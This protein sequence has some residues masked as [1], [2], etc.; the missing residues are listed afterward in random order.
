MPTER[1]TGL[2]P[3]LP[4]LDVMLRQLTTDDVVGRLWTGD[5]SLWHPSADTQA[6]I[7]QRLGWLQLPASL[8]PTLDA[9]IESVAMSGYTSVVIVVAGAAAATARLWR[10]AA[11]SPPHTLNIVLIDTIEPVAASALLGNLD[12]EQAVVVFLGVELS[13][14]LIALCT[15]VI[16]RLD[17][18]SWNQNR[19]LVVTTPES[20]LEQ[21]LKP[22]ISA[23]VIMLPPTVSERFGALSALGWV[24]ARLYGHN[25]ADAVQAAGQMRQA[26]HNTADLHANP[27]VWLGVVLGVLAQQGR[28]ILTLVASPAL[29]P[30]AHWIASFVAGS[31]SKHR[32]GF[33]PVVDETFMPLGYRNNRIFVHIS[34][35]DDMNPNLSRHLNALEAAEQPVVR[36]TLT[37]SADIGAEIARWEVAVAVA[38]III[39]LN[40]FDEP[41]ADAMQRF[42]Q[43]RIEVKLLPETTNAM[44]VLHHDFAATLRLL[45][46]R[47]RRAGYVALVCYFEPGHESRIQLDAICTLLQQRYQLAALLVYPLR[48]NIASAQL[49]HAGRDNGI[50]VAL[51]TESK[52]D[53]DVPE[54]DEALGQL[55]I[56]RFEADL[57]G[58]QRLGHTHLAVNL[59]ANA[60]DGLRH[61]QT[62]FA[63]I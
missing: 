1:I 60:G 26:C 9:W 49:L 37:N 4:L 42:T 8:E 47:D 58:W 28:D 57:I 27:G 12:V 51:I 25:V 48:D 50:F 22:Q 35:A 10:S 44:S 53:M 36:F 34:L 6:R 32:R 62:V 43:R 56:A 30:L 24:P 38:A 3:C 7:K 14:E 11:Y 23:R 29:T 40:P 31:L 19:L 63:Q 39:G 15:L 20:L 55:C 61:L 5:A 59:G 18:R 17:C 54:H 46:E 45:L 41:D 21:W 16:T 33:V 13:L 52:H 2:Q